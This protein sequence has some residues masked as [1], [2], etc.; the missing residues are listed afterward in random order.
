VSYIIQR[1]A[2]N[3]RIAATSLPQSVSP[4]QKLPYRKPAAVRTIGIS[5]EK[6]VFNGY[7]NPNTNPKTLTMLNLTLID[8]H[9]YKEILNTT[10]SYNLSQHTKSG[11]LCL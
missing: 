7:T 5:E 3:L 9:V 4:F 11:N 10:R 6:F 1:I 2:N 8:T